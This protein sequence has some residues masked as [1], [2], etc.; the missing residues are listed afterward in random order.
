MSSTVQ[1]PRYIG[2]PSSWSVFSVCSASDDDDAAPRRRFLRR[3]VHRHSRLCDRFNLQ[4]VPRQSRLD[5][6]SPTVA[7][8]SCL[9][10]KVRHSAS[11]AHKCAVVMPRYIAPSIDISLAYIHEKSGCGTTTYSTRA[12]STCSAGQSSVD[13]SVTV[14]PESQL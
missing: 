6:T 5:S 14:L 12:D 4:S 2:F 11:L 8:S 9:P 3:H 1:R 10:F 13:P 7:S